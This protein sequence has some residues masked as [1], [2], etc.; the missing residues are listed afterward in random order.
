MEEDK[1]PGSKQGE[2]REDCRQ[3]DEQQDSMQDAGGQDCGENN[4][5]QDCGEDGG[6]QDVREGD[7]GRDSGETD[8][9][10]E[11]RPDNNGQ[12]D[13]QD[14]TMQEDEDTGHDVLTFEREMI[15]NGGDVESEHPMNEM[16]S[17]GEI[18]NELESLENLLVPVT[19]LS[20]KED[21][22]SGG[23]IKPFA[24]TPPKF[25]KSKS[26]K[27]KFG[28]KSFPVNLPIR[29]MLSLT[30][31]Q[32]ILEGSVEG[33]MDNGEE[34]EE[35]EFEDEKELEGGNKFGIISEEERRLLHLHQ[36]P[37][38]IPHVPTVTKRAS[39]CLQDKIA[40]IKEL[41][42]GEKQ[43]WICK[44]K[45]LPKS[46]VQSIWKNRAK[47][48]EASVRVG[49]GRKRCRRPQHENIEHK[50]VEWIDTLKSQNVP[51]N[52]PQ[53]RAKAQ[54]F[55][56]QLGIHKFRSSTGWLDKFKTRHN[57]SFKKSMKLNGN[58][59]GVGD[60]K[61]AVDWV[62]KVWPSVCE[63]YT[64]QNIFNADEFGLFYSALPDV[65]SKLMHE[66]C[67]GGRMAQERLTVL[68]IANS[69]GTEKRPLTVVG[70]HNLIG[71][72]NVQNLPVTYLSDSKSWMTRQIFVEEL[73][74]WDGE[75]RDSNRNVLLVVDNSPC[76]TVTE[77]FSNIKLV[78]LP[79]IVASILQPLD[80]GVVEQVKG[81]YRR[82]LLDRVI[83][84]MQLLPSQEEKSLE[85]AVNILEAMVMLNAAW[86]SIPRNAICECFK[87]ANLQSIHM[88]TTMAL[89]PKTKHSKSDFD[90]VLMQKL[91]SLVPI[92]AVSFN[93]YNQIDAK[94][95][96]T[97]FI[98]DE[99]LFRNVNPVSTIS[100]PEMTVPSKV[101][102]QDYLSSI[103]NWIMT[104]PVNVEDK[105]IHEAIS[106]LDNFVLRQSSSTD[107]R[108][109]TFPVTSNLGLAR[110]GQLNRVLLNSLNNNISFGSSSN[111]LAVPQNSTTN[112]ATVVTFTLADSASQ[113][114]L[115]HHIMDQQQ[116]FAYLS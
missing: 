47:I 37:V 83:S 3:D 85:G 62:T 116:F 31:K 35:D 110:S 108:Q 96:V 114:S 97:D 67:H 43:S 61:V 104:L 1:N 113:S 40:I 73:R 44:K 72:F 11:Y 60:K 54:F 103:R 84:K 75:L 68:L 82:L 58:S 42:I 56:N 15:E 52:G 50:L 80:R 98:S 102:V 77:T 63:G 55:A 88:S 91:V 4:D 64:S 99:H 20:T 9:G 24:F 57:I 28:K 81:Q 18:S 30:P 48:V 34:D 6:G 46:T 101:Q 94:L 115:P 78:F 26:R 12:G 36:N 95:H 22:L 49:M 33:I 27:G 111:V 38:F 53:L 86:T 13:C 89:T 71:H 10:Q 8:H 87:N 7:D 51:V 25:S 66:T 109:V 16:S 14:E 2:E 5:G 107:P 92:P 32:E 21:D 93:Y 69:D 45:C 76:H 17:D 41:E 19:V 79:P 59:S 70:S 74:K 29:H 23:D 112:A 65:A 105:G 39:L 90:D 106:I 100:L